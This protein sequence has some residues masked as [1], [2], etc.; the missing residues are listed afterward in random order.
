MHESDAAANTA[1]HRGWR[2]DQ[3]VGRSQGRR[4]V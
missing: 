3:L 1:N 2:H 4:Y